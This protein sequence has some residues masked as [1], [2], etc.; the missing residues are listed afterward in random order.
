MATALTF[1]AC[2]DLVADV[3]LPRFGRSLMRAAKEVVDADYCS[4]FAFPAGEPPT[5]LATS[6]IR[7]DHSAV[8]ASRHY[9]DRHW[10]NDPVM[11]LPAAPKS[12]VRRGCD[13]VDLRYRDECFDRLDIGDRLILLFEDA[14]SRLRLSFYRFRSREIFRDEDVSC[15]MRASGLFEKAARRHYHLVDR[16]A[17]DAV[18]GRPKLA[19]IARRLASRGAR[20]SPRETAVCSRIVAGYT[21]EGIALDLS[22]GVAS[23]VTYR[24]RAYAKLAIATQNELFALCLAEG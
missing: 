12:L 11:A 18:K 2:G 8:E 7:S 1:D 21:T 13:G 9:V 6:G 15:V 16:A 17:V 24:K 14:E 20:L 5:C 4:L 3:G 23:V 22:V 19:A 10:R